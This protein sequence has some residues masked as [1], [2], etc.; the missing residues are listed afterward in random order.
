M[1]PR[2]NGLGSIGCSTARLTAII[3]QVVAYPHRSHKI[4]PGERVHGQQNTRAVIASRVRM[5]PVY[6]HVLHLCYQGNFSGTGYDVPVL[7]MQCQP[8][9]VM[10]VLISTTRCN[11]GLWNEE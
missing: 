1:R 4:K 8:P 5:Q 3:R 6:R 11:D 2:E 9:V 10:P 7:Q